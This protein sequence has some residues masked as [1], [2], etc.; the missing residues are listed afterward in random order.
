M[1]FIEYPKMLV[2]EGVERIVETAEQDAA[3]VAEGFKFVGAGKLPE[4]TPASSADAVSPPKAFEEYPKMLFKGE[5]HII[6]AGEDEEL[7]A[8]EAGYAGHDQDPLDHDGDG[9]KGG[10]RGRKPKT[11]TTEA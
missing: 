9:K 10:S 3:A 5:Q 1:E 4:G 6:V 8:L 2:R 7:T 11:E